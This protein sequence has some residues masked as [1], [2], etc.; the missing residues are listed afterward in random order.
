M[1]R[2]SY[3]EVQRLQE[4]CTIHNLEY[5]ILS[6]HH[7]QIRGM[8]IVNWYPHS[9][10]RTVYVAGATEGIPNCNADMVVSI[11]QG[12]YKKKISNRV[13]V[14]RSSAWSKRTRRRLYNKSPLCFW[15]GAPLTLETCT[16]EH[17]IPLSMGGSNRQDNLA[18][19]CKPCN[20]GRGNQMGEPPQITEEPTK[21]PEE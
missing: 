12:T 3:K 7:H 19:A 1:T 14:R 18:L 11:A 13:G 4:L 8:H 6:V 15:C 20:H 16:L 9:K 2:G 5:K 10:R 21:T 17:K